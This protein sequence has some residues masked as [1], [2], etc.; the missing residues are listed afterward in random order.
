M[1]FGRANRANTDPPGSVDLVAWRGMP[2]WKGNAGCVGNLPKSFSGTLDDPV[3]SE[4]GRRFLT[5]LLDQLSDAQL[6]DLFEAGRVDVRLREPGVA[7][8]GL[9]R[10]DEWV[11]AFKAKRREIDERHCGG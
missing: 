7:R 10:A 4:D 3:I 5:A 1:T 2:V 9:T 11:E 8:S 6:R